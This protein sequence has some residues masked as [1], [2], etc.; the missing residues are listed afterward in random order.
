MVAKIFF[1]PKI[2]KIAK[3]T[4]VTRRLIWGKHNSVSD[5]TAFRNGEFSLA[6]KNC[7]G[8][9]DACMTETTL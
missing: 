5:F 8:Q 2:E 4:V 9:Q 7:S 6:D 3:E 1:Q